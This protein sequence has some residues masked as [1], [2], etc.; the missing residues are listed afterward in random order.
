MPF[1]YIRTVRF[2]DTDA[3]GVV[4]FANV[5]SMCHEAYEESLA[6]SGV[7]LPSF[8]RN[9]DIAIPIIH[10]SID[11]F[12]PLFCGDVIVI[13]L[14]PNQLNNEKFEINYQIVAAASPHPQS[15]SHEGRGDLVAK[16]ITQHVC[17]D[18]VV[19]AKKVMPEEVIQWLRRWSDL[20]TNS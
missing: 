20:A 16:A 2:Q 14:I 15:L 11:F 19:R 3:A 1:N 4:Y 18:P 12:R 8:F 13:Q 10:A 9:S 17:I 6:A 7:N 5:L